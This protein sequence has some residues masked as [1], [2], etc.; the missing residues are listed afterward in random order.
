MGIK[1]NVGCGGNILEGWENHDMDMDITKPLPFKDGSVEFILAEHV[2]EHISAP[3]ALRF[4]QEAWRILEP[5]GIL[6]VCCPCVVGDE[7]E[8]SWKERIDLTIGH[9][10]QQIIGVQTLAA[11][12]QMAGFENIWESDKQSCDGHWRVIGPHKDDLE[13]IRMEGV[14]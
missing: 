8:V 5:K 4:F 14:K 7:C 3:D 13:T 2:V 11:F 12:Y 9:G 10:H 1:L 6:R